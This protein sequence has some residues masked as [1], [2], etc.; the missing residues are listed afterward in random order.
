MKALILAAGMGWRLG[1]D[2]PPKCL[3]EFAG[4][5]LLARHLEVLAALGVGRAV[6]GI[7]Y[8]HEHIERA[9]ARI[10]AAIPVETVF[11]PDYEE[12]NVV[13]LW[14]LRAHLDGRGPLLLMD[15]DV[16]CDRRLLERLVGS[17]HENCLLLDRDFEE[18][19]EPVKVCVRGGRVVE[20]GRIVP[21]GVSCDFAGESVGFFKIDGGAA[22]RLR[23]VVEAFAGGPRRDALYEEALREMLVREPGLEFGFED[24]T[25]LPW[26]QIDFRSDIDR[27]NREVLPR[28]IPLAAPS[29]RALVG[30]PG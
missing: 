12:G 18:G 19:E 1:G 24:V 23:S 8:R 9:L 16:L 22:R 10:D 15:A 26:T 6:I 3:L 27:A 20:L 17:P 7:G 28:L 13:T 11:N 5:S 4:R 25:G 30:N 14:R 29:L 21:E 2:R